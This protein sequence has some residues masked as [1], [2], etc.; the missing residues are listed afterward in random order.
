MR[1]I[2]IAIAIPTLWPILVYLIDFSLR[3]I[4]GNIHSGGLPDAIHYALIIST[5]IIAGLTTI[6]VLGRK[7]SGLAIFPAALAD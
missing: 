4:N 2:I 5:V 3:T 1:R 7:W 6:W